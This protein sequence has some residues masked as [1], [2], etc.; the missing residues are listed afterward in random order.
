MA[1][2]RALPSGL[3]RLARHVSKTSGAEGAILNA[4]E[5]YLA[6]IGHHPVTGATSKS[7]ALQIARCFAAQPAAASAAT[8][9]G[10]ITQ[11][12]EANPKAR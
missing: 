7:S 1:Y 9:V 6:S 11:V 5:S 2:R 10:K 12:G 4:G 8:N 3:Q